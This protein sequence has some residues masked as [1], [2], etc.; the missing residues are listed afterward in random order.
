MCVTYGSRPCRAFFPTHGLTHK[1]ALHG[2]YRSS[3]A[4]IESV[5]KKIEKHTISETAKID[6]F[7]FIN[8]KNK[9]K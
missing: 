5:P 7:L 3:L 9:T 1:K 4:V 6:I 2:G 8:Y